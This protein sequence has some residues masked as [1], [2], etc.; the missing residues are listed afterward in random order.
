MR[1]GVAVRGAIMGVTVIMGAVRMPVIV[2][3]MIGGSPFAVIMPFHS[4]APARDAVPVPALEAAR[5]KR[6]G[7]GRQGVLEDLFRHSEVTK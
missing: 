5:G 4:E 7:E 1:M 3:V 2:M 6:N